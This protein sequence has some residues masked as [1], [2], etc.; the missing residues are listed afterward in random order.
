MVIIMLDVP[1]LELNRTK[2]GFPSRG[3]IK[4]SASCAEIAPINHLWN[5]ECHHGYISITK[6]GEGEY[7]ASIKHRTW[8]MISPPSIN[9]PTHFM[10]R[11]KAYN[12]LRVI[13][14]GGS[15]GAVAHTCSVTLPPLGLQSSI[16]AR[17]LNSKVDGVVVLSY[18]IFSVEQKMGRN[19]SHGI[20]GR[21]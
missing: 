4:D 8:S 1:E 9:G 13:H 5:K 6:Q 19:S 15:V 7:G 18:G 16:T 14:Y 11:E 2:N 21:P 12:Q 10:R 3:A 17:H 20:D